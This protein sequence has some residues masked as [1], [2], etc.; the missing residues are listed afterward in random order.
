VI[1]AES[2]LLLFSPSITRNLRAIATAAA[3]DMAYR[4]VNEVLAARTQATVSRLS[5]T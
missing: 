2:R 5:R 1:E 4:A 3:I